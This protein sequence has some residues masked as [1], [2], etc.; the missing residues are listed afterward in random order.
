VTIFDLKNNIN[1]KITLDKKKNKIWTLT[2]NIKNEGYGIYSNEGKKFLRNQFNKKLDEDRIQ[3]QSKTFYDFTNP[4]EQP[5]SSWNWDGPTI[6]LR[7]ASGGLLPIVYCQNKYW[8]LLFF[9]D[10][11]PVGLNVANGASEEE[12]QLTDLQ[13]LMERE[14]CEEIILL[15]SSDLANRSGLR[16]DQ[17]VFRP[18]RQY[19]HFNLNKDFAKKHKELR[20]RFDGITIDM[21]ETQRTRREITILETPFRVEVDG[22]EESTTDVIYS[23]NLAGGEFGFEV[24][25]ICCFDMDIKNECIVD[26]EYDLFYE[27]LIRRPPVMVSMDYL[28]KL[29]NQ[30][31][32]SFGPLESGT[33]NKILPVVL[34]DGTKLEDHYHVFSADVNLRQLRLEELERKRKL[35]NKDD[36]WEYY[37]LIKPWEEKYGNIFKT[38]PNNRFPA[39][40]DFL[41]KNE[42]KASESLRTL[43]PVTWKTLETIFTHRDRIDY[44]IF[45]K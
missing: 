27:R 37:T 14:F 43:I 10:I 20:E 41:D 1:Q 26:G 32:K 22:A 18:R 15:N 36:V 39:P 28:E 24:L 11:R 7:W 19:R 9:R 29:Y 21:R 16:V 17:F 45:D 44:R 5:G 25:W 42:S 23:L 31:Q 38:V 4:N 33:D 13:K 8:A 6:P 2:V 35:T 3:I 34:N 30:N 40:P 12:T